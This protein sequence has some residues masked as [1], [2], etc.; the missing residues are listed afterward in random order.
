MTPHRPILRSLGALLVLVPLASGAQPTKALVK[1]EAEFPEPF[2]SIV[3]IRVLRD[4]RVV[5]A[6]NRDKVVQ[7]VDLAKKTAVKI[8]REGSGPS[9]YGLPG[10]LVAL[11]GDTSAVFDP[12]NSRYLTI[13]PDGKAG[14][15]FRLEA[16]AAPAAPSPDG[17]PR[18]MMQTIMP[19]RGA[20]ASGRLYFEGAPLVMGP[21]GPVASDSAPVMRFDRKAQRYDTL[22]FV[23]LAKNTAQV[24]SSS[25]GGNQRLSVNIGGAMPFPSRDAWSVGP[26]GTVTIVR[27]KNFAL[28]IIAPNKQVTRGPAVPYT[29]V[30][31]GSAEKEE[32]RDAQ[33]RS[34]AM[35]IMRSNDNGKVTTTAAPPPTSEPTEWP[36]T[37]PAFTSAVLT[38]PN[39]EIWVPRSRAASDEIPRYDVFSKDGTRVR[40]VT[41]PKKTR[42]VG[43]GNGGAI[44]TV[45]LDE[46]DLQYL[47]RFRG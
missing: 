34:P 36:A 39:G 42:I 29:P 38:A 4:G 23:Q 43:F 25:S 6:D 27:V 17:A 15:T 30:R 16:K 13:L 24:Q 35:A 46:D 2:S 47:Q 40:T 18:M 32:Y 26:D 37:K 20:D 41:L 45:R 8:G 12:L 21:N 19:P 7:L 5:V 9:E 28:E 14:S 1:A 10:Q 3:G 44:Y 33:K 11:P 22:A 31:V